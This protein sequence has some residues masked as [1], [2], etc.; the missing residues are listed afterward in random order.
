MNEWQDVA[1]SLQYDIHTVQRIRQKAGNTKQCCQE[2]LEDWLSTSN[3][4]KPKVWSVLLNALGRVVAVTEVI[5]AQINQLNSSSTHQGK[6]ISYVYIW[7]LTN[8]CLCK[9][10]YLEI[11]IL[12]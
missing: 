6:S 3:G 7:L 9:F 5:I 12:K 2:L 1:Y 4:A 11:I 10:H 8:L